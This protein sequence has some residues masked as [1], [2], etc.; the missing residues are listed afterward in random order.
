[1]QWDVGASSLNDSIQPESSRDDKRK[2]C[3]PEP[4]EDDR[5]QTHRS[6]Y[7]KDNRWQT[8]R[9]EYPKADRWQTHLPEYPKDDRWQTHQSEYPKDDRWQTH[10][11]E[12]PKADRWQTH[13]HESSR[14]DRWRGRPLFIQAGSGE[15]IVSTS[16]PHEFETTPN[17][18]SVTQRY[19]TCHNATTS[20]Q[21]NFPYPVGPSPCTPNTRQV[22]DKRYSSH[23][24]INHHG[25]LPTN[26]PSAGPSR[27][28]KHTHDVYNSSTCEQTP[29][30]RLQ[31]P[32]IPPRVPPGSEPHQGSR[33][34]RDIPLSHTGKKVVAIDCE[35]VGCLHVDVPRMMAAGVS[36]HEVLNKPRMKQSKKQRKKS[37]AREIS[38]AGQCSIVDYHGNVL[39]HKYIKP[40]LRI[41]DLRTRFNGITWKDLKTATPF[42]CAKEEILEILDD[43]IV[44]GHAIWNDTDAL[45]ISIPEDRIRDTSLYPLLPNIAGLASSHPPSLKNLAKSLLGRDIQK[46]SHSS[47]EDARVTMEIYKIVEGQWECD[48]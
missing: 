2:R 38:V 9:S 35:M 37:I 21:L 17:Q 29:P 48:V 42:D 33:S 36:I 41:V 23:V 16:R 15:R 13:Q 46:G 47:L 20:K 6:E 25:L 22:V 1:M 11:S 8:H 24:P 43:C 32:P 12:Y 3:R 45:T 5:W 10:R 39:Y 27:V 18:H 14:D 28:L 34:T 7:P 26:T 44:V 40:N 19:A 4:A 31:L 30:F